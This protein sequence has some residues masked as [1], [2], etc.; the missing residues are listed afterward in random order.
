MLECVR[1]CSANMSVY[2]HKSVHMGGRLMWFLIV[3][4]CCLIFSTHVLPWRF[5]PLSS[6]PQ[7][8]ILKKEKEFEKGSRKATNHRWIMGNDVTAMSEIPSPH[9][10]CNKAEVSVWPI[11]CELSPLRVRGVFLWR[12]WVKVFKRDN[13]K[14]GTNTTCCPSA[15]IPTSYYKEKQRRVSPPPPHPRQSNFDR[16]LIKEMY[17]YCALKTKC[18]SWY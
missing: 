8:L 17:S 15:G 3:F 9:P 5:Q 10:Q 6:H 13:Q 2:I 14:H 12:S 4:V 7:A 16:K 1:A 11:E 18:G